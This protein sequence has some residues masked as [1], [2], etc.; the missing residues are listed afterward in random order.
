MADDGFCCGCKDGLRQTIGFDQ[1][2]WERNFANFSC[3][4]IILPP[5]AGDVTS[6]DTF[7]WQ[8]LRFSHEHGAACEFLFEAVKWCWEFSCAEDVIWSDVLSQVA[9]KEREVCEDGVCGGEGCGK[10]DVESREP[11]RGDDQQLV[12]TMI[13]DV[14]DFAS[15]DGCQAGELRFPQNSHGR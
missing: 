1:V 9:P 10:D 13:I 7:D 15:R 11:V 5:G 8:R 2:G 3:G 14:T 12:A 4:P 6:Y